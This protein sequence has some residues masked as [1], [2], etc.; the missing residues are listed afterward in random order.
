MITIDK[1]YM[2]KRESFKKAKVRADQSDLEEEASTG[3]ITRKSTRAKK[4][5]RKFFGWAR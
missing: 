5:N 1:I 2:V 4:P 3:Q